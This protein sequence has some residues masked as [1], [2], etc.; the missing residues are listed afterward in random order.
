MNKNILLNT[1]SYKASHFAMYPKGC[2]LL[3]CYIESRGGPYKETVFFGLQAF[4]IE[5]LSTPI[6]AADI[7][8]AE[9]ILIQHGLPFNRGSWEYILDKHAGY[10]PIEIEAV[11]EG[12]VIPTH[13]VLLQIRNTDPAC[14]WLPTYLETALLR[15]IWYPT[16]VATVSWD[17]KRSVFSNISGKLQFLITKQQAHRNSRQLRCS[18]LAAT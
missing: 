9:G 11:A 7:D 16:T 13:E 6:T 17:C 18:A 14:F 15:A 8:E 4:L 2:E 12:C 3:S 1:D 10:L 5:Y